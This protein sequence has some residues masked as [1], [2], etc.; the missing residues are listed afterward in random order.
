[1]RGQVLTPERERALKTKDVFRECTDCP[2]MIVVPAGEFMMGSPEDE[3]DRSS[4]EGPRH[5][6]LIARPVAVA[7]FELTFDEWD[8]CAAHGDCDPHVSDSERGRGRQ[9]VINVSWNDAQSYVEWLSRLTGQRYR[10]LT[11]AEWEYAARAGTTTVYYWGNEIG[12]GN[13][14]CKECGSPW[15]WKT[16]APAGSFAANAFGLY[17]MAGNVWQWA[18]DCYHAGYNGAPTDGSAWSGGDCSRRVY[19]GGSWVDE[20][21][22]LRSASRA[23]VSMGNRAN[24]HGFRVARTLTP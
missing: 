21:R 4:D 5:R 17:D 24:G 13:A 2:E 19:R 23:R 10:L 7:R 20:A 3:K 8:A 22:T 1:M 9:P 6:V 14:N 12:K 18:Q 16:P 11:E 15:D